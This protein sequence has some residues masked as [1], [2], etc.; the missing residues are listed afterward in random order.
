[1]SGDYTA[2]NRSTYDRIAHSYVE[3]QRRLQTEGERL[4]SVLEDRLVDT[5]PPGGSLAD[6]GCGPALDGER[7]ARRGLAVIGLDLSA[8]MLAFA[9]ER[10][11]GRVTQGDLRSLPIG[12]GRLDGIWC[13]A[14]LLHVPAHETKSVLQEFRRALRPTGALGLVTALGEGSR[15]E[16]VPYAVGE[17]RW[18]VYRRRSTLNEQLARAG[19]AIRWSDEVDGTRHWLM[20]LAHSA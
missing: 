9:A 1:M 3:R 16:P 4:F 20:V 15:F 7:F 13:A 18:F 5:L 17:R 11:I 6:L 2:Q 14:A 12:S 10:L 8:G 19:L